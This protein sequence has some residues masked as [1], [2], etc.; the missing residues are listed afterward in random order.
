MK[1]DVATFNSVSLMVFACGAVV[2]L[3]LSR[4]FPQVK[5]LRLWMIGFILMTGSVMSYATSAAL[6]M[7]WLLVVA[8]TLNFQYRILT[9]CGVRVL[10]GASA[11]L[12]TG[13]VVCLAFCVIYSIAF[14]LELPK[15]CLAGLVALFFVPFRALTVYEVCKRQR[16]HLWLGRALVAPGSFI[17]T[18]NAIV[19]LGLVL[20]DR[21]S[22]AMLIGSP[23]TTAGFYFVVFAGD[24]LVVVG[25]I[26]LAMQQII[27]EKGIFARLDHATTRIR[28]SMLAVPREDAKQGETET[29]DPA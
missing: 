9:W 16:Q 5:S 25:L 17:L 8:A 1:F 29:L 21:G 19:P 28:K 3:T 6:Q 12:R 22:S 4:I 7:D 23:A 27:T 20:L 15:I 13:G 10:F 2:T 14:A 18:I 11:R 24:L 26:V